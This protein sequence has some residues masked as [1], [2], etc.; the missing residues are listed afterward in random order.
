MTTELQRR[1]FTPEEY[2]AI[3]RAAEFKSEYID[4]DIFAMSGASYRHTMIAGNVYAHLHAQLRTRPC[5]VHMSD[6]RIATD[7]RRHYAYPD[8]VV[9]CDAPQFVDDEFDTLTNPKVIVE[10]LSDS[11]EKYDRGAKFERYRGIATLT[12]YV[13]IAQD[14]VHLEIFARQADGSWMLRE[15]SN[16][17]ETIELVSIECRLNVAEIYEK[18]TFDA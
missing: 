2:L 5:T 15:C 4:G 17:A 14:R 10:V 12:E 18:V 6:L 1:R 3:E 8:V 13:L 16:P 7:P 11:T 9:T